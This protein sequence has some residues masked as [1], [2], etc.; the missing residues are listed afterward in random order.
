MLKFALP[1]FAGSQMTSNFFFISKFCVCAIHCLPC[2]LIC[3]TIFVNRYPLGC[4][5]VCTTYRKIYFYLKV[6]FYDFQ[7][8]AYLELTPSSYYLYPMYK[9]NLKYLSECCRFRNTQIKLNQ[10]AH[11][12]VHKYFRVR[13]IRFRDNQNF[14]SCVLISEVSLKI[15]SSK[16]LQYHNETVYT[17]QHFFQQHF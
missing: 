4:T 1:N 5:S 2:Q 14:F 10:E 15:L 9:R 7:N 3:L 6:Y 16:I 11:T 8:R 17:F 13:H 12:T